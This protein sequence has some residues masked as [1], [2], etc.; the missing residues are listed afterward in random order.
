MEKQNLQLIRD[1]LFKTFI[2][3][4]VFAILLITLTMLFWEQWS[5]FLYGKFLITDK[6]L[7]KLFVNSV[8][9]LR[10]YL[11]FVILTP[12]IALHWILKC[13]NSK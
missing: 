5:S 9:H 6:E 3:G 8:L 7:G 11:L 1:F 12:A 4:I 2:I 13:K 10:F